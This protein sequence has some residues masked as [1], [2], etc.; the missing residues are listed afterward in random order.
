MFY[1][2]SLIP[3]RSS[4]NTLYLLASNVSK[5]IN[6]GT[7]IDDDEYESSFGSWKKERYYLK[8]YYCSCSDVLSL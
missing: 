2:L 3:N 8:K 4:P 7:E 6:T 1:P 5:K